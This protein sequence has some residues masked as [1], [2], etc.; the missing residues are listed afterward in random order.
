MKR[1]LVCC[2]LYLQFEHIF[3]SKL[4]IK[5]YCAMLEQVLPNKINTLKTF[6]S[7]QRL[8]FGEEQTGCYPPN[9]IQIILTLQYGSL[10]SVRPASRKA[11][12]DIL[13]YIALKIYDISPF[14]EGLQ[15][16]LIQRCIWLIWDRY[17]IPTGTKLAA[18]KKQE[19]LFYVTSVNICK[20]I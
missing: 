18:M 6:C 4:E 5:T 8:I 19:K 12:L 9:P 3:G 1:D 13:Q 17:H 14:A 20:L 10:I 7:K 15:S 2:W 16:S 11:C